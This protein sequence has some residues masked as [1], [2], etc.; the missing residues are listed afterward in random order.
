MIGNEHVMVDLLG[1]TV[2]VSWE[3]EKVDGAVMLSYG[4]VVEWVSSNGVVF[5]GCLGRIGAE[6]LKSESYGSFKLVVWE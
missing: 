1:V 4:R 2:L 5:V 3:L 6:P